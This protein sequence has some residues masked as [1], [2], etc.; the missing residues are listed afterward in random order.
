MITIYFKE[1]NK[2]NDNQIF[3]EKE[4]STVSGGRYAGPVFRY[5]IK[6]GDCLSVLAQRYHTSIEVLMELNPDIT[7]PNLIYEGRTMLI[8]YNG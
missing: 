2:M 5:I 4:L 6:K 8:P 7:N 1:D 3:N